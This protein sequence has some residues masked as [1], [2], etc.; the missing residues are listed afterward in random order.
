[1]G[2]KNLGSALK[3]CP[4][5]RLRLLED[6]WGS[7]VKADT[8]YHTSLIS[9]SNSAFVATTNAPNLTY[10]YNTFQGKKKWHESQPFHLFIAAL[11]SVSVC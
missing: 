11:F 2:L 6:K 4:T 3:G 9:P 10:T 1:M 7:A 5:E 8:R